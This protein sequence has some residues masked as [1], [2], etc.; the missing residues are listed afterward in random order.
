M[1]YG[2]DISVFVEDKKG[3]VGAPGSS[4]WWLSPDVDIPAHT[5]TAFQG[6][7]TVQIRVHSHEEPIIDEKIV[8]EVY[9]GNPSLVMSP[10][11]GTKRIDPGNLLFRPPNVSGTEPVANDVGGTLTF[12]WTPS[13]NSADPDGPGHRCL[14]VRAFP[15]SVSPPTSPFDVPND[16]HE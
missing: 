6:S 2:T 15:Q 12:A 9:A 7:N 11:T 1:A 8:A 3:D 10:T 16:A 5:G 4:P 14:V 13:S